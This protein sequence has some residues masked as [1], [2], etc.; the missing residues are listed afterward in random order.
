MLIINRISYFFVPQFNGKD[1]CY[2]S[3]CRRNCQNQVPYFGFIWVKGKNRE[4]NA[5]NSM[6]IDG[7]E[8]E[9]EQYG[10][11]NPKQWLTEWECVTIFNKFITENKIQIKS[12]RI[13]AVDVNQNLNDNHGND[14][15]A[16]DA[17]DFNEQTEEISNNQYINYDDESGM[18]ISLQD[19]FPNLYDDSSEPNRIVCTICFNDVPKG[20]VIG[21]LNN[22]TGLTFSIDQSDLPILM[23]N[24]SNEN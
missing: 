2:L 7:C 11:E 10:D 9:F 21:H 8:H 5:A 12:N 19:F 4:P 15:F 13:Q 6:W 24:K 17:H 20:N 1:K 16:F 18:F 14:S 22:C 3:R 23:I